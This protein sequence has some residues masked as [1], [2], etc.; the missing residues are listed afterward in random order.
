MSRQAIFIAVAAAALVGAAALTI[1]LTSGG[2]GQAPYADMSLS[3]G[4]LEERI[5]RLEETLDEQALAL[6]RLLSRER[7][8]DRDLAI[9]RPSSEDGAGEEKVEVSAEDAQRV[10]ARLADL[11]TRIRGLEEDP[12]QRGY[13]FLGSGNADL[14][15]QGILA[16]ERIAKDDPAAKATIRQML[17]DQD[18]RVRMTA[19]DTLADIGD[20]ESIPS[21]MNFLADPDRN[22]RQQAMRSLQEMNAREAGPAIAE[23]LKDDDPRLRSQAADIV[24]RMR[25][26]E[27]ADL[28][29]QAL[30]DERNE[31]KGE[32]IASLGEIGAKEAVPYLREM[33]ENDPGQ[34]RVRLLRSL[35]SL[36]DAKP[37][38][39]EVN[40]LATVVRTDGNEDARRRAMWTLAWLSPEKSKAVLQQAL[41]DPS[42][43]IR[44]EAARA[45]R[46]E[47]GNRSGGRGR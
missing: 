38:A 18:P 43:R 45:L 25:V 30:A 19:I 33:Y 22:V 27:S 8:Y 17:A 28:L 39:D 4:T 9:D 40:R 37:L 20:R 14:R 13:D 3:V 7:A 24:G 42:E 15:R 35:A 10:L 47:G 23:L 36:G 44:Q 12:I 26:K 32:V 29:I 5:A 1:L 6:D 21:I 2:L 16:L 34:H 31:V 11:E 46:G 41:Q